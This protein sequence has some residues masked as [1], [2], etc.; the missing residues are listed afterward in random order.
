MNNP[1]P[2]GYA[3][4]ST[5]LVL[6]VVIIVLAGA[7]AVRLSGQLT[8]GTAVVAVHDAERAA[9]ACVETA[10]QRL[11]TDAAYDG[12]ETVTVGPNVC[13]ILPIV[14]AGGVTTIQT[15]AT[16]DGHPYR[17][18]VELDDLETVH[19]SSWSHVTAF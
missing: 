6:C 12:D 16:V 5:V 4:V 8:Q 19:V 3:I 2:R 9:E 18:E 1:T 7:T 13:D 17:I 10:L 15:E 14:T 11:R